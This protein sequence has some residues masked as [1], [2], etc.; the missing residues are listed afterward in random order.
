MNKNE[1]MKAMI[2]GKKIVDLTHKMIHFYSFEDG[3][4][5]FTDEKGQKMTAKMPE[6][7]SYQIFV[8][9]KTRTLRGYTTKA[10]MEILRNPELERAQP[11]FTLEKTKQSYMEIR[12]SWEEE[13]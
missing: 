6:H 3:G 7:N 9:K 11:T 8:I 12:I 4:F 2:D 10:C 1:A 5:K 13:G